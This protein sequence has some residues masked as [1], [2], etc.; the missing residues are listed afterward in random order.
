MFTERWAVFL[1][2]AN[3]AGFFPA[4]NCA[5]G[6]NGMF[7]LAVGTAGKNVLPLSAC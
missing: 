3:E 7:Q 4:G 1:M 6:F 5:L 2:V